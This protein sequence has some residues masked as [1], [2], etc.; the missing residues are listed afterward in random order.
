MSGPSSAAF[1]QNR[2]LSI[3][4]LAIIAQ[5][6]LW[7]P[8]KGLKHW[9]RTAEKARRTGDVLSEDG[10][11]ERA[12]VEL[13]R[14]AT[15]VLEKL[16]MHRDYTVLLNA[17]QR[18][19]LAMVSSCLV[20]SSSAI[21]ERPLVVWVWLALTA[22]LHRCPI[23]DYPCHTTLGPILPGSHFTTSSTIMVQASDRIGSL[24]G[25]CERA[26]LS[27]V[28]SPF[29]AVSSLKCSVNCLSVYVRPLLVASSFFLVES[30]L[31]C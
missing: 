10:D 24:L 25:H 1:D 12:F 19:N 11:Y 4:E 28:D 13:A 14:A 6:N 23:R 17:E 31:C 15:I 8:S 20:L 30:S 21:C 16:P 2:P 22:N 26:S 9:L 7:D 29:F 27:L 3:T 18:N 5:E